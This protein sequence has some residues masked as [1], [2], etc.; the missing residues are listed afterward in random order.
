MEE[1]RGKVELKNGS[2]QGV[3]SWPH[4]PSWMLGIEWPMQTM[5]WRWRGV[6]KVRA[7]G[8]DNGEWN[9]V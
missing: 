6:A 9:N 4:I 1:G 5:R 3:D 2:Y 8:A 7:L